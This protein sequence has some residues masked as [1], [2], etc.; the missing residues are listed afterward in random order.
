VI[1]NWETLVSAYAQE[2]GTAG[3]LA[4]IGFQPITSPQNPNGSRWFSYALG[5][6]NLVMT[7]TVFTDFSACDVGHFLNSTFVV[8]SDTYTHGGTAA[9]RVLGPNF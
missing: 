1:A 5:G 8:A 3:T 6:G 4:Q 2:T 7:A 9:C